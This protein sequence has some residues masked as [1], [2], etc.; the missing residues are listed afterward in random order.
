MVMKGI[1][2]LVAGVSL[3]ACSVG[4]AT[5]RSTM[6]GKPGGDVFE[7]PVIPPWAI[8]FSHVKAPLKTVA[9]GSD[10]G[11][12]VGTAKTGYFNYYVDFAWGEMAI[13][14][15]AKNGNITQV[16]AADYDWLNVLGIYQEVTVRVYG[17]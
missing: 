14:E 6:T 12:K 13:R 10:F 15:A 8:I 4:C 7:G 17:D 1:L 5:G 9:N 16:K 11:T 3:M 2:L